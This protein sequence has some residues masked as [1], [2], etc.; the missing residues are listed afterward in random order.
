MFPSRRALHVW[1]RDLESWKRF[2]VSFFVAA[3]GDPIF[4]LLGIGYG[5]GRFVADI[6][7]QPY[8]A[9]LAPGIV[10]YTAMNSATFEATVGSF[11]RM[12]EQRT[13]E[14]ILATP[15]SVADIVAGDVLWSASKSVISVC[16]LA[17]ILTVAGLL[18]H[19]LALTLLPLG[20]VVGLMFASL[21]M[22]VTAKAPSYDFFNYYF[23]FVFSIM[24]LFSGVF[25]PLDT[26]PGWARAVAWVLP[27]THAVTLSR[28]LATG[29]VGTWMVGEVVWIAVVTV[30][31]FL[32]AERLV[33]RRLL[34]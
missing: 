12:S 27:L 4:Y 7:G 30:A 20:F 34:V 16:F 24:F 10:A 6:D 13:Y 18:R 26:L 8:A 22:V 21:G 25:F 5:L 32:L 1:R 2:A 33:R 31:A 28:G 15:C 19:P 11:T 23:T 29:T 3:L 17:A 14:A 9:F